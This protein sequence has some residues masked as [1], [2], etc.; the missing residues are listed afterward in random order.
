MLLAI[1]APVGQF[2]LQLVLP[3]GP[4]RHAVP[5]RLRPSPAGATSLLTRVSTGG[6]RQL[7]APGPRQVPKGDTGPSPPCTR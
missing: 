3:D 7:L 1:V 4:A 6:C 5:G 2:L